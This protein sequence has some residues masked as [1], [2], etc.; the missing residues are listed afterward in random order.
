[1]LLIDSL[2]ISDIN[3]FAFSIKR[4]SL[5]DFF[6]HGHFS[7]NPIM[8]GV[9]IVEIIAQTAAAM[10]LYITGKINYNVYLISVKNANFRKIIRPNDRL[11]IIVKKKYYKGN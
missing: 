1:M 8:P 4:L 10:V 3:D 6:F 7:K 9:F 11:K 5:K 2:G